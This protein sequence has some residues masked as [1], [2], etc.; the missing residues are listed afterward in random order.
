MTADPFALHPNLRDLIQDPATSDF[1]SLSTAGVMERL[2]C[3]GMPTD[4]LRSDTE[5]ETLRRAFLSGLSGDLWVF[6]YG[7]LMWDPGLHFSQVRRAHV[8]GYARRMILRD[9]NGARG[10]PEAPGLMA[11]LDHGPEGCDGLVFR[12]DAGLVEAE[13]TVLWQREMIGR[14]YIPVMV[15]ADTFNG[16]VTCMTFIAD[17]SADSMVAGLTR[18]EQVRYIATGAGFIGTSLDYLRGI[19]RHFEVLGIDDQA[20]SSLLAEAEAVAISLA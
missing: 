15:P 3:N 8:P 20:V 11:A 1:R 19:A 2:Q 6:A 13:T 7:S 14:G 16:P 12:I 9:V 10:T 18:E 5:R 4:W 17:H